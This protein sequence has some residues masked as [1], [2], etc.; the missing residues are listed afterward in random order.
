MAI[1]GWTAIYLAITQDK[2]QEFFAGSAAALEGSL[3]RLSQS[4]QV[5]R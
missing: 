3:G 4:A 2:Q 5:N 1:Q